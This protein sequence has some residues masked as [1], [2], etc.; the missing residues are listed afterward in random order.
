M[1]RRPMGKDTAMPPE[2]DVTRAHR[3]TWV[4]PAVSGAIALLLSP[5]AAVYLAAGA[6]V[7]G[8]IGVVEGLRRNPDAELPRTLLVA[9]GVC[10]GL[11]PYYLAAIIP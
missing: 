3:T 8:F 7:V 5:L 6:M 9:V 1:A 10:F 4:L 11:M 2:A